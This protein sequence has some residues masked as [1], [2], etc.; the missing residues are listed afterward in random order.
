MVT[1]ILIIVGMLLLYTII[2]T[3]LARRA[4]HLADTAKLS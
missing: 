3:V 4:T 1:L 2:V